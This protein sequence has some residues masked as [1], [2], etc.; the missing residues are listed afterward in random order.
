MQ[1]K[2]RLINHVTVIEIAGRFDKFAAPPVVTCLEEVTQAHAPHILVNMNAVHFVDSTGLATLVQGLK[3]ARQQG[4]D[5]YLCC[6]QQPV[7][8]IFELTRLDKAFDIFVDEEHAL[9]TFA[10]Q[11]AVPP[12]TRPDEGEPPVAR[13]GTLASGEA[14][15]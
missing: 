14:R 4:G 7:Y 15:S 9:Q 3:R 5:L 12:G 13:R 8:M 11:P 1:L 10:T 2:T 6:L